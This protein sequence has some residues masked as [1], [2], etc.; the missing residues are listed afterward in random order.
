MTGLCQSILRHLAA[1]SIA[2]SGGAADVRAE[3]SEI[4][5]EVVSEVVDDAESDDWHPEDRLSVLSLLAQDGRGT[6]RARVAEA[7]AALW[8][9]APPEAE[10]ILRDLAHDRSANVRSGAA[11]GLALALEHAS[12]LERLHLVCEWT[13]SE[14]PAE[15]AALAEALSSRTPVFVTDLVIEQLARDPEAGVRRAALKAAAGHF[16]ERPELYHRVAA[17]LVSDPDRHVRHA[18]RRLASRSV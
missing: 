16:D 3:L 7:M 15:R 2:V 1:V 12:P 17:S 4:P 10:V 13:I 8:P 9:A 14:C 11:R 6:V 18:A 5:V